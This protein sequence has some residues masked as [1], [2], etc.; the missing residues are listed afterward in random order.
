VLFTKHNPFFVFYLNFSFFQRDVKQSHI[1][2]ETNTKK[3]AKSLANV[4]VPLV[5]SGGARVGC[6]RSFMHLHEAGN[7]N[8]FKQSAETEEHVQNK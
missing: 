7:R 2:R 6:Q 8:M 4:L 1:S 3:E 5:V